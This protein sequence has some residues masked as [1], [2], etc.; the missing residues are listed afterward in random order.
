MFKKIETW[1]YNIQLENWGWP[2][3]ILFSAIL[4]IFLYPF[5]AGWVLV[6]LKALVFTAVAVILFALGYEAWQKIKKDP[7][8]TRKGFLQDMAGNCLGLLLGALIV[9]YLIY[10]L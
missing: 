4:F 5:F 9:V 6:V 7:S 2:W 3:H 8:S 1:I 10:T